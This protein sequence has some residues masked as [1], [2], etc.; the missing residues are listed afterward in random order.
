M[1]EQMK[2]M[3]GVLSTAERI[4]YR[5]CLYCEWHPVHQGHAPECPTRLHDHTD[6]EG[7]E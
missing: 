1:S 7:R 3:P 6:E 5:R 2:P 4:R